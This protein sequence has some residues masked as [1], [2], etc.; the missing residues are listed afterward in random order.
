MI[1]RKNHS[2]R[3]ESKNMTIPRVR[4][5]HFPNLTPIPDKKIGVFLYI[6]IYYVYIKYRNFFAVNHLT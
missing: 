5:F 1:S 3:T 2:T 4:H 6:Y